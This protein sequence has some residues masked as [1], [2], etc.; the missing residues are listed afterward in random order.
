MIQQI[1]QKQLMDYWHYSNGHKI[2]NILAQNLAWSNVRGFVDNLKNPDVVMFMCQQEACFL[3]GNSKAENLKEFLVKIPE[4]AFIYVPSQEWES[5]LKPQWTYFGHFPRTE[6]SAKNLSL[7]SIRGL[8]N[9]LPK[10]FQMKKVDV[11][12][13]KQILTQN[14]SNHLRELKKIFGSPEKFVEDVI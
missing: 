5:S 6:L 2:R 3:T 4:K 10:G 13:A 14:F 12:A 7:Q 11:E 8:L 9:S 1:P